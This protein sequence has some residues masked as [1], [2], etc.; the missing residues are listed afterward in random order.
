MKR[1]AGR[2]LSA[3]A[4]LFLMAFGATSQA[5]TIQDHAKLK[6]AYDVTSTLRASYTL[7][8]WGNQAQRGSDSYLRDAAG[9]PVYRGDANNFVN[10]GGKN[11]QLELGRDASRWSCRLDGREVEVDA[12]AV[13]DNAL[14]ERLA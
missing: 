10:I 9:A 8:W 5:H 6:L 14:K 7:G 2:S 1:R 4:S 3:A 13:I 11:Y 12:I